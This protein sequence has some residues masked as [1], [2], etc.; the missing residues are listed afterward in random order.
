MV[1]AL[2]R[3]TPVVLGTLPLRDEIAANHL[4]DEHRLAGGLIERAVFTED[5]RRRAADIARRLVHAAR[6]N[7]GNHCR[8]LRT[9][10]AAPSPLAGEGPAT[11]AA[12]LL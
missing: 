7:K 6:A 12:T 5:E 9:A 11:A 1:A 3:E 8:H 2:K 4:I 10:V